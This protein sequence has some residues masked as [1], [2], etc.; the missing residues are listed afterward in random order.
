MAIKRCGECADFDGYE[1][2]CTAPKILKPII[3]K[4]SRACRDFR[5]ATELA[6]DAE[7]GRGE[8]GRH[9][10]HELL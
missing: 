5:I 9:D 8:R 2:E 4:N 7:H 6:E 1:L 10:Q 3:T